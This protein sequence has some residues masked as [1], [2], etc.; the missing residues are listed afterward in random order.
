MAISS[1]RNMNLTLDYVFS[2]LST[3]L[4]I[5]PCEGKIQEAVYTIARNGDGL[6][7]SDRTCSFLVTA[8]P[9]I[10]ITYIAQFRYLNGVCDLLRTDKTQL[11]REVLSGLEGVQ[12]GNSSPNSICCRV[13]MADLSEV[14]EF[15][16]HHIV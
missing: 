8:I 12:L 3:D 11:A 2:R 15:T 1:K 10:G 4:G 9:E 5:T 13:Q 6:W 14:V 7:Y 16:R